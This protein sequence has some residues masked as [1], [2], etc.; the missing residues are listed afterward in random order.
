MRAATGA[1][2][3]PGCLT[4]LFNIVEF[5]FFL[6]GNILLDFFSNSRFR[7]LKHRYAVVRDWQRL[8]I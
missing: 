3:G 4:Q 5:S 6:L 1:Y 2:F 7:R 8:T